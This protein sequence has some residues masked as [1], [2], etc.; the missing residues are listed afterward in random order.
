MLVKE[1]SQ[2]KKIHIFDNYYFRADESQF[3]LCENVVR[4][5]RKDNSEYTDEETL[6]YFP[7]IQSLCKG[8]IKICML[9]SVSDWRVDSLKDVI[10]RAEEVERKLEDILKY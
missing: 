5:S 6:G 8:L 3:I 2:L 10:R 4:T 9:R 1:E 7:S